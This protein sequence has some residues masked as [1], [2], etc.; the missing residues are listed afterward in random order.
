MKNLPYK[1][2]VMKHHYDKGQTDESQ[3]DPPHNT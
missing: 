1:T 3:R 2:P